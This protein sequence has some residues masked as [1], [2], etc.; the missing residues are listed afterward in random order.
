MEGRG[1]TLAP[2]LLGSEQF[3]SLQDLC[4]NILAKKY[5][6]SK[7]PKTFLKEEGLRLE[8]FFFRTLVP[9]FP[10]KSRG[11][12]VLKIMFTSP[13]P[14]FVP[15]KKRVRDAKKSVIYVQ[16]GTAFG[17]MEVSVW[18]YFLNYCRVERK[19]SEFA[20]VI[21]TPL[22]PSASSLEKIIS[23]VTIRGKLLSDAFRYLRSRGKWD[24][25]HAC[26]KGHFGFTL[27]DKTAFQFKGAP[28]SEGFERDLFA[29]QAVS[30]APRQGLPRFVRNNLQ[31]DLDW[32][33][34]AAKKW[35]NLMLQKL[36]SPEM[37]KRGEKDLIDEEIQ[38]GD[39][40]DFWAHNLYECDC[41]F[42]ML[43]TSQ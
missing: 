16:T 31:R 43:M 18:E 28:Y 30:L 33:R 7:H 1:V 23:K 15:G 14:Y 13:F 12:F 21:S 2:L 25:G 22:P 11:L 20:I 24:F 40:A 6:Y 17:C 19:V 27:N 29:S 42:C 37:L 8:N 5:M 3:P 38:R 32:I 34:G 26:L 41:D 9:L 4:L 39:E 10:K 36:N 35:L